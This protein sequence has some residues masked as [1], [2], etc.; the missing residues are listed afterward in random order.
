MAVSVI[1][2]SYKSEEF[3]D[4]ALHSI[5]GKDIQLIVIEDKDGIGPAE[6]RNR[7]LARA[8]GEF[9]VF[10][11]SDDYMEP[12]AIDLM[13]E[14]I[15]GV[16]LVCGSF[17]KFGNFE[18]KVTHKTDVLF[19]VDLAYY[20]MSNLK[21]PSKNQMLSGCWAKMFR[22][23]RVVSFPD[24]TTAEDMAFN[25]SYL[26]KCERVRFLSNIVYH[27]RKRQGSL[28]T[29]FDEK[30]KPGLFGFLKG[31]KYVRSF[32]LPY[33]P[34]E[35]IDDAIDSSKVYHAALYALRMSG[36]STTE[37]KKVLLSI[38]YG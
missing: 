13:R 8:T 4:Q 2:P 6:A 32:L 34:I 29:T 19:P 22:M 31:L 38:N 36:L 10:C 20:V 27:N 3:I 1:V 18:M 17:R 16:D 14:E 28:S 23:D 33:Y 30:N 25:F 15:E 21:N 12:G 7:G 11:D 37:I 24:L 35:E 26:K 5:R 9:I